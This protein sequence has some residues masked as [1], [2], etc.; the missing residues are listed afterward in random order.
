M[1]KSTLS[2]IASIGLLPV[3]SL[4]SAD[5]IMNGNFSSGNVGF[6]S[7][8][9]LAG[10]NS[11]EGQYTVGTNPRDFNNGAADFGD[12]SSGTGPMLIVNGSPAP[13]QAA[14]SQTITVTPFTDYLFSA[15]AVS[16]GGGGT[17]PS[18]STL[19]LFIDGVAVG[20]VFGVPS[21]NGEWE[22]MLVPWASGAGDSLLLTIVD[23]NTTRNGNDFALDDINVANV[24]A[25]NIALLLLAGFA[26]LFPY[27][28]NKHGI[29]RTEWE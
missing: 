27:L 10:V 8:Y 14:W 5:L 20:S 21:T 1:H 15:W 3:S 29:R 23:T 25:P 18:P 26:P 13:S 6:A 19:Q 24:P 16:W 2:A 7:D 4:V 9:I 22:Q 28:R 17:D 12:H 11:E